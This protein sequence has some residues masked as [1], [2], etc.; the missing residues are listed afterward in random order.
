MKN[1]LHLKRKYMFVEILLFLKLKGRSDNNVMP[2]LK[3]LIME[4]LKTS[5]LCQKLEILIKRTEV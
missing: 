3:A 2:L 4:D 5:L 1:I